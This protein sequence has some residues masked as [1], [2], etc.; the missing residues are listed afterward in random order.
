MGHKIT[1]LGYDKLFEELNFLNNT[2]LPAI[3]KEVVIARALGDLSENA[4]YQSAKAEQR[5]CNSRIRYLSMILN[6]LN[7][8]PLPTDDS[9]IYF[10]SIVLLKDY[11]KDIEREFQIVC[12]YE[13]EFYKNGLS[14]ESPLGKL[15]NGKEVGEIVQFREKEYEVLKIKTI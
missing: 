11:E 10:G 12:E 3:I 9:K 13:T 4:E 2:K 6:N 1:K 7:I 8:T 15:L 5:K 14:A